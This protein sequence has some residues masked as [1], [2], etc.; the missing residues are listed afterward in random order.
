MKISASIVLYKSDPVMVEELIQCFFN[1]SLNGA[2]YLIDNSPT[3]ELLELIGSN[4]KIRYYHLPNNPGFGTAHNF[5]IREVIGKGDYHFII[6]PDIKF[7]SEVIKELILWTK[8]KEDVGAVMPRVVYPNNQV[9]FL[10]KILPSPFILVIRRIRL[11][12]PLYKKKC[13]QYELRHIEPRNLKNVPFLSGCF[14]LLDLN[15][16][17]EELLFDERY[18]MFFEDVDLCRKLNK[19]GLKTLYCNDVTVI[20]DH[21]A[22]SFFK[23]K[24]LKM[25]L[26]S[27]IQYFNK[28]GW[29]YDSDRE[30]YNKKAIEQIE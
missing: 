28:W 18:F 7:G 13:D 9:Q 4:S 16:L 26:Q 8:G 11:L 25:Y 6:N 2:L 15:N 27:A 29:F 21:V 30:Y 12:K 1:S 17:N 19:A 22:K 14:L 10:T 24:Y 20:H 3:D 5:A 23:G